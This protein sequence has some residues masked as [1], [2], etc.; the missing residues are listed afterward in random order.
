MCE[1]PPDAGLAPRV[2]LHPVGTVQLP[3]QFYQTTPIRT[4]FATEPVN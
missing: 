4:F 1:S 3:S 2:R